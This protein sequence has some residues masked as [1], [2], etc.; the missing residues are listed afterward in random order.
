MVNDIRQRMVIVGGG[1]AGWMC[2]A[3]LARFAPPSTAITLVESE[4]IGTVGVGEATIPPIRLFN[5][6]IGL[7]EATFLRETSATYKLGIAFDGW[8]RE[9]ESYMH[10]FGT[11]GR[12]YEQVPFRHHWARGRAH[13]L[14]LPLAHYSANEVAARSGRMATGVHGPGIPE[15]PWAYHFDASAYAA[16]LRRQCEAQGVVRRE[17]RIARAIRAEDGDIAAVATDEGDRIEGDFFF[18][19]SGFRA[20]LI[21]GELATGYEDWRRW[22]PCDRAWAV[23][24]AAAGGLYALYP[25]HGAHS[26]VAM[27]N[28]PATP[29]RQ[30]AGL[31]QRVHATMLQQ[32]ICCSAGLTLRRS[33][34]PRRCRSQRGGGGRCGTAMCWHWGWRRGSWNRWNPLRSI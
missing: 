27:A 20:L 30:R 28:S 33:R 14:A 13:G 19:C 21:E 16:L 32:R 10:A 18:D 8:L 24:C 2:A 5:K 25:C 7:D 12:P 23:P 34:R 6:A 9:G 15:L 31:L 3:A 11:I 22:L 29:H 4:A 26:G 1:T 17:A